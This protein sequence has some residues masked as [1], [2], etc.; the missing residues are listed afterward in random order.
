MSVNDEGR[1]H[2]GYGKPP[3]ETQFRR[4][5]SGNPKGRPKGRLNLATVIQQILREKIVINENGVRRAVTKLEAAL[6]QL[7]DKAAGGDIAAIRQL[8]AFAVLADL[9]TAGVEPK[10]QLSDSEL[11]LMNRV[12]ERLQQGKGQNDHK[13]E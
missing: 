10:A 5:V 6:K 12:L 11:K 2:G 3:K 7:A 13:D 8:V 9:E 4:G 1:F